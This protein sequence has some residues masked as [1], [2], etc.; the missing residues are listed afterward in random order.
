MHFLH[1]KSGI[2]ALES[3]KLI[4]QIIKPQL[5]LF[6]GGPLDVEVSLL[7]RVLVTHPSMKTVHFNLIPN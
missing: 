6:Y 1:H 3:Q 7:S 4:L 2:E 5:Y